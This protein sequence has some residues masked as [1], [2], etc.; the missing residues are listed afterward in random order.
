VQIIKRALVS[1]TFGFLCLCADRNLAF[2]GPAS[3]D[4]EATGLVAKMTPDELDTML[5]G[6]FARPDRTHQPLPPNVL[7]SAG[8][9]PG[10]PRLSIPALQE[11]DASVGVAWINGLRRQGGTA[12]P[13]SIALAATWD[14]EI[15][16]TGSAMIAREAR[17]DGMNV[18]LA[19][20]INLMRDP[21]NGRN[22]EYLGEDPL[23]AGVLGGATIRGVQDQKVLSTV[24][25]FALNAQETGRH[26]LSANIADESARESDLLAFEIA[27]EQGRPGAVMCSYNKFNNVHACENGYLL[28]K[29]LKED[30]R[31]PGFVM[32]DWGAVYSTAAALS[33]LDQESG[34]NLDSQVFFGGP[35]T[36]VIMTDPKYANRAKDMNHRILRSMISVGL[37]DKQVSDIS[38]DSS[39]DAAVSQQEAANGIVLLKN[40]GALPLTRKARKI[41][42][43]GGYAN[44]GVMSGG[45]SSQVEPVQGPALAIPVEGSRI[46]QFHPS[47][48][49]A[50]IIAKESPQTRVVFDDGRYPA[51]SARLAAQSDV[52]IVFASQ[53]TTEGFDLPDL[54]LP[55]GQDALIM[56]VTA[57]N[58]H[59]I[60]VLET[61]GPVFMPWLSSAAAVLEAWYPGI[62]G[63][64]A[65]ADVLYGDTN[66]SGR[67]PVTFPSS[68]DQLPRPKLDGLD[69]GSLSIFSFNKLGDRSF[70]QFDVDYNIE[71]SHVGYRWFSRQRLSPLFPF[72]FGLSYTS[73]RYDQPVF[74]GSK[75]VSVTVKVTNTGSTA[76]KD[77]PQ[78]YLLARNGRDEKRLV[79]W[80]KVSLTPGESKLISI[81]AD[82][83]LLADWSESR[84]GWDLQKG[85]YQ[86]SL[87]RSA[88]DSAAIGTVPVDGRIL[89]P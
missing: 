85:E 49:L 74:T 53:W 68:L 82:P 63:G 12:L 4:A 84:H 69:T 81:A 35:L 71:G 22:F 58:P 46:I 64:E 48:P 57:A 83:R 70:G 18:L 9:I 20:G 10:I 86:L 75:T 34:E 1:L 87:S 14:P 11:T 43:I 31:Y 60:V 39:A 55:Q 13:S 59:T 45:G 77:T 17:A 42:V 25:H 24:K 41:A 79:G 51:Y 73:F 15:A 80:S 61:G 50:A 26:D 5:H 40:D 37:M 7:P 16:Y 78:L 21:R 88:T 44:I 29:V 36:S 38:I 47:S 56:A 76:G 54:S 27:I 28:D 89:P 32:S 67:L 19:G 6:I 2:A 72:G 3:P 33:G 62:R 30:W 52:V 8:Y 65:I 66:P 23:L